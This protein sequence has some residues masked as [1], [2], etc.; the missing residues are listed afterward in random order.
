MSRFRP[1]AHV[2]LLVS[3]A[4]AC[5]ADGALAAGRPIA[6]P[7]S[8]AV[9]AQAG[10]CDAT[11]D[12]AALASA[13]WQRVFNDDFDG[14]LAQWSTWTG[15]AYNNELQHY[16]AANLS[17]ANGVLSIAA[18][19]ETVTGA[20]NPWDPTPKTFAFTSGRIESATAFSAGVTGPRVRMSARIRL[21]AGTGMWPAFWSYGDP[22]PTQGE[23]D[24]LEARGSAPY[25]YQTAYW[26][27]RRAGR[28]LVRN[29][30]KVIASAASLM[31]CWH[32][33]EVVWAQNTLTFLLDGQVV[34]TKSGGYIPDMYRKQQRVVLNVAV[35]GDFFT[36]LSPAAIVPGTLQADWVKV[37][38][39]N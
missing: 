28:N 5:A 26:Y 32:V 3:G 10:T 12:E 2:I 8:A 14:T 21:P 24:I 30:A 37:F 15:G 34:D 39:A 20:T 31:D 9:Q 7:P 6:A 29:S 13:G 38:T 23:I 25:E 1:L 17:L 33:V 18:R 36:N 16:Q 35:G 22:W 27:G 4:A 19:R 11:L